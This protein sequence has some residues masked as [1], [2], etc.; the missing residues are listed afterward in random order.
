MSD[1]EVGFIKK[2]VRKPTTLDEEFK[3]FKVD[4]P[5]PVKGNKKIDMVVK[6]Y[7][8]P[9]QKTTPLGLPSVDESV[10]Q[11][12]AGSPKT[13]KYGKAFDHFKNKGDP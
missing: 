13:G 10:L 3:T 2:N 9:A 11:I 6:G 7:G 12:L 5:D 8:L 1:D 4:N